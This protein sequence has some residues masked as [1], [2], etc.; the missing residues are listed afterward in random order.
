MK[1]SKDNPKEKMT[2]DLADQNITID[3]TGREFHFAMD[4][5]KK[6]CLIKGISETEYLIN[7]KNVIEDYELKLN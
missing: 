2:I 4:E 6:E 3:A 1:F 5:F 7:L